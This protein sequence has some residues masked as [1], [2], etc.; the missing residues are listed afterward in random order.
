LVPKSRLGLPFI[1]CGRLQGDRFAVLTELSC[2][3]S[4]VRHAGELT[5]RASD[6]Y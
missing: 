6:P 1:K 2:F 5:E 3:N 4:R